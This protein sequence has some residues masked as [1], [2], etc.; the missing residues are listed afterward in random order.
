M[1]LTKYRGK[2]ACAA[3]IAGQR[4]RLSTGLDATEENRP[5]AE[6]KASEIVALLHASIEETVGEIFARYLARE[7]LNDTTRQTYSWKA[8]GSTFGPLMPGQ[9]TEKKCEDYIKLR[10]RAGVSNG[11]IRREMTDLGSALRYADAKTPAELLLPKAP[12]ARDIALSKTEVRRLLE[13][14]SELPHLRLYI[15]LAI[16]TAGRK[17]AVLALKWEPEKREDG[18]V[19]L[20]ERRIYL[21]TKKGG[22]ERSTVPINSTLFKELSAAKASAET[23]YVVEYQGKPVG[24]IRKS[25]D[26]AVERSGITVCTPHDLRHTAAMFMVDE[27]VPLERISAYLGHSDVRVTMKVY[28]KYYSRHLTGAAKALEL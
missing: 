16:G 10:R 5:A 27:G 9:V 28:A 25:F 22:K 12:P 17:A 20:Q 23:N 11:T 14:A 2:W 24:N 13:A 4:K 21:G 19:D 8:L 6:R 7:D 1:S 18:Y 3:V 15:H 26:R